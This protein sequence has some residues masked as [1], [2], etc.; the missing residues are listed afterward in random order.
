MGNLLITGGAG[1]IGS[2]LATIAANE[3]WNVI[4]L[5]ILSTGLE[6]T[7]KSLESKGIEVNIGDIRDRSLVAHLVGKSDAVVHLAAQ[8][9]VPLSV[10]NPAETIKIRWETP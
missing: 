6:A 4:V 7:A 2:R 3:G 10:E 5:D 8:V 1:F 9:S